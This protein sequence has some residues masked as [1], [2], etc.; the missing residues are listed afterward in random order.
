MRKIWAKS[1]NMGSDNNQ[2]QKIVTN[3]DKDLFLWRTP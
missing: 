3:L 1:G 2:M